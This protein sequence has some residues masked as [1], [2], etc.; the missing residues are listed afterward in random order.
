MVVCNLYTF[1]QAHGVAQDLQNVN[2]HG[3]DVTSIQQV[4][5]TYPTHTSSHKSTM[6]THTNIHNTA[7][8][9]CLTASGWFK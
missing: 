5:G 1:Y 2:T 3:M 9:T 8:A 4:S 6:R 7:I